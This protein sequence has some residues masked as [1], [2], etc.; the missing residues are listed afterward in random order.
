MSDMLRFWLT[1]VGITL[2]ICALTLAHHI[3]D[4]REAKQRKAIEKPLRYQ[5]LTVTTAD[6]KRFYVTT[7]QNSFRLNQRSIQ[8][9]SPETAPH[10][11]H[12]FEKQYYGHLAIK[13]WQPVIAGRDAEAAELAGVY[14]NCEK[15]H[16]KIR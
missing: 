11:V 13:S 8:A 9:R 12:L 5:D 10:I 7:A 4:Q 16:P 14:L 6:G 3:L 15:I 2:S 1:V